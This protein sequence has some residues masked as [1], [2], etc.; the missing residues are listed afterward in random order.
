MRVIGVLHLIILLHPHT[1]LPQ[2]K[3]GL[4]PL[5]EFKSHLKPV[6]K[7][8]HLQIPGKNLNPIHQVLG[9]N[10]T[11]VKHHLQQIGINSL[12]NLQKKHQYLS[13]MKTFGINLIIF[14]RNL[15]HP[16]HLFGTK[17]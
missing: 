13:Q 6:Q 14:G 10:L 11:R 5:T 1:L 15:Q 2:V 3:D 17:F 12:K 8:Q 9:I 4:S 7:I 16:Y